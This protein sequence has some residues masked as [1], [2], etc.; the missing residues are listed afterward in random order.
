MWFIRIIIFPI[1]IQ[2][3]KHRYFFFY[4]FDDDINKYKGKK[5]KKNERQGLVNANTSIA[6]KNSDK[7]FLNSRYDR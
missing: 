3:A 7:K 6:R 1:S 4:K 5:R 2:R